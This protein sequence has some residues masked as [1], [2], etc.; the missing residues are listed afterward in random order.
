[1]RSPTARI[2]QIRNFD[3]ETGLP[4]ATYLGQRLH[5]EIARAAGR[6]NSLVYASVASRTA[7]RSRASPGRATSRRV[8]ARA[9]R[10]AA[11][12]AARLRRAGAA[13]H[14]RVRGPDARAGRLP[15]ER[16]FELARAVADV[17]SKHET[18]NQPVR[19]G[20][21]FGY[22]VHPDDGNDR[23]A[24]LAHARTPRIRMV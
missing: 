9:R 1:M 12:E 11:R 7:R 19:V 20:L 6:E 3:E 21:A 4:N 18:L 13:R 10:G 22:A 24:L 8:V 16:I 15:G 14:R 23:E 2:L 17:V 5:E